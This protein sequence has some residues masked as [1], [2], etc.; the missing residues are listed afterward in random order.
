[1]CQQLSKLNLE[2][3]KSCIKYGVTL[4]PLFNTFIEYFARCVGLVKIKDSVFGLNNLADSRFFH[5]VHLTLT[6]DHSG[7]ES[8]GNGTYSCFTVE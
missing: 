4:L 2:K 5:E 3:W 1:M 7:G 8:T 6:Q